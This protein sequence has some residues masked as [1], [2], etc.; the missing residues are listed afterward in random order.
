MGQNKTTQKITLLDGTY[1]AS[2]DTLA[3]LKIP[4][5]NYLG[6]TVRGFSTVVQYVR[7]EI[8]RFPIEHYEELHY[9]GLVTHDENDVDNTE[10]RYLLN[11]G[12]TFFHVRDS[13]LQRSTY[14]SAFIT[15]E[16]TETTT[17]DTYVD[18]T[19]RFIDRD[20][21]VFQSILQYLENPLVTLHAIP[22]AS[23]EYYGINT[24]PDICMSCRKH[25]A[26]TM[27]EH[28]H[29]LCADCHVT[30]EC[31]FCGS[32][33]FTKCKLTSCTTQGTSRTPA[34]SWHIPNTRDGALFAL[35]LQGYGKSRLLNGTDDIYYTHTNYRHTVNSM[36]VQK[37]IL[38][39]SK[40]QQHTIWSA[41]LTK[42]DSVP[43]DILGDSYITIEVPARISEPQAQ[44][45]FQTY[46]VYFGD[47][48][49][50]S[51]R[52]DGLALALWE[53]KKSTSIELEYFEIEGK[54]STRVTMPLFFYFYKNPS[55]YVKCWPCNVALRFEFVQHEHASMYDIS[56]VYMTYMMIYSDAHP[57]HLNSA[58]R[59]MSSPI[60]R[61]IEKSII[62]DVKEDT[63][64]KKIP[65][66]VTGLCQHMFLIVSRV[67][68]L[69]EDHR[70]PLLNFKLSLNDHMYIDLDAVFMRRIL[71][72]A[73]HDVAQIDDTTRHAIYFIPFCNRDPG[74]PHKFTSHIN[75]EKAE[76]VMA[77]F[78]MQRGTYKVT[79]V[80]SEYN[81]LQCIDGVVS[82][83]IS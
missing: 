39:K 22:K 19:Y 6:R 17:H 27:C 54:T 38:S 36:A 40:R 57:R 48:A 80:M 10:K 75:F 83:H 8:D 69:E 24:S 62:V 74:R 53:H 13:V 7:N 64:T 37:A 51:Y 2:H 3:F 5:N 77:S 29:K 60:L 23:F 21:L 68:D 49:I 63:A 52:E 56:H 78:T 72:R 30:D 11:V 35:V 45:L 70:E 79:Y 71:P 26:H 16:S 82:F 32:Y 1:T 34:N 31:Q 28:G 14:L 12:G 15:W 25:N 42:K 66:E 55:M 44:T 47:V 20:P 65:L 46:T 73:M 76:S 67:D 81:I 41:T 58:V 43:F 61:K 18:L 33:S 59:H 9:H 50:D 4:K